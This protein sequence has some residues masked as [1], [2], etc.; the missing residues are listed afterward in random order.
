MPYIRQRCDAGKTREYLYYYTPRYH[1]RESCRKEKKNPTPEA[2]RKVNSRMAE[3]KLTRIMNANFDGT[4]YYITFSYGKEKRP[5]DREELRRDVGKLLRALRKIYRDNGR[6]LKYIWVAEVGERGAAHLHMIV[7]EI[8]AAKLKK[9]WDKG[10]ITIKPLDDIGQ[11]R[12]LASYFIKYSEKTMR[13]AE[14][15]S[16]KRYNSSKNLKIPEPEKK[17]I[18]SRNAYSHKII[19]PPGWYLDKESV[20]EAEHEITGYLYFAYTLIRCKGKSEN[21][22]RYEYDPETEEIK[23]ERT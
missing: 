16:G 5:A 7:N 18:T 12:K 13:T 21:R 20:Q 2:Q 3:R 11:Y 8:E 22:R 9:V 23:E 6:E 14:G 4:S 17:A 19:V 15:F 1:S 10:W